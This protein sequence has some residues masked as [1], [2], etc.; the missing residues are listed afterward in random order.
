MTEAP[1]VSLPFIEAS[2]VETNTGKACRWHGKAA[3]CRWRARRGLSSAR[4]HEMATKIMLAAGVVK[5]MLDLAACMQRTTTAD[6][7]WQL[8]VWR[9]TTSEGSTCSTIIVGRLGL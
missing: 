6:V 5:W 9:G 3:R 1:L 2:L 7:A 4:A 8:S